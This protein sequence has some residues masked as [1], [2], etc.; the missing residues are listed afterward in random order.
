[1]LT[2]I[3]GLTLSC[4]DPEASRA[5]YALVLGEELR[6]GDTVIELVE[7]GGGLSGAT[8]ASN[9]LAGDTRALERRGLTLADGQVEVSGLT[10]RLQ[11][12]KA[13]RSD[14][15]AILDHVVVRTNDP[16]RA[17]ADYGARLGLDLRLDRTS[18]EWGMRALFFRC[19][20]TIL[21]IVSP[22]PPADDAAGDRWGGFAVRV[23]DI[24]AV[25]SRV[26]DAGYA[27]SDVRP[28]RKPGTR[29]CTLKDEAFA[30]PTL[31]LDRRG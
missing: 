7:G 28:G 9:D 6:A 27:V 25:R 26:A 2:G 30:G 18:P 13:N 31:L 10:W 11:Q 14:Y 24:E 1:M 23:S 5:A 22:E 8:F 4:A 21:E 19:G 20:G 16:E 17:A 15:S 12:A 29:V 3:P